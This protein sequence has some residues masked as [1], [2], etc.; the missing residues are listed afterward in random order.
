MIISY[1]IQIQEYIQLLGKHAGT[2]KKWV[3]FMLSK[4]LIIFA[5][6]TKEQ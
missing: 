6:N 4:G 3:I 5:K 2:P 1:I